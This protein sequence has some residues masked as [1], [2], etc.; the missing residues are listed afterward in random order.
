MIGW[1]TDEPGE[2]GAFAVNPNLVEALPSINSF[3]IVEIE[4]EL[5]KKVP[6]KYPRF[7][8]RAGLEGS[9][10]IKAL[11]SKTGTVLEAVVYKSS[12]IEQLDA[13]ALKVA[14]QYLYKPAIQSNKPVA[15]WVTYR[16]D[17]VL[18]D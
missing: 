10:W 15:V 11:V 3:V 8:E 9:V 18:E 5:I 2:P 16:V 12:G 17:F 6:P 13:A 1:G 14:G 4:A 7:A